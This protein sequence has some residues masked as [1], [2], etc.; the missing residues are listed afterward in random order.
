MK[1]VNVL[2]PGKNSHLEIAEF[3][4]PQPES[5]EILVKIKATALN[6]ADLLQRAGNYPSPEGASNIL[7]LEMAG[8]VDK[9]GDKVTKWEAG[10]RIS[11]L[12]AGGGY[13][14]YC[15]IHEDMAIPVPDSL[16]FSQ[17]AAI[18]ETFLTAFQTLVWLGKLQK[19]ET[20]LVHAGGSGVGT[21]AIQLAHHLVGAQIATTAGK[22]RK[23][24]TAKKLGADFAYNY[25]EQDWAKEITN[26][27]GSESIDLIVDFIGAPYWKKNIDVLA[28]DGRVVYLSFLGGHRL[29]NMSLAPLLAKRLKIMGSTLRSRSLDYK[30]ALTQDF[31]KKTLHFFENGT[32]EP[33][34][35]SEY[36]WKEAEQAHQRM[37]D[38]K[39]TGK[40]VLTGM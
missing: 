1:A 19:K 5:D 26:D 9:V 23:L 17:A 18:P 8:V 4:T 6:R 10:D 39:N 27:I 15:V 28:T 32:L 37:A 21:S 16:S 7:G 3:P 24:D 11:A 30:I 38:N 34:I 20:V 36:D 25:K 12:L 13:A 35:D 31:V 2:N 29:E 14:Q 33:V 22:E 40:I